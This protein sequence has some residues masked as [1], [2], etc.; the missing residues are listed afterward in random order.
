[1][2]VLHT[3]RWNFFVTLLGLITARSARVKRLG[4]AVVALLATSALAERPRLGVVIVIDQLS[5]E[6]FN[7]RLP[8]VTGGIKRLVDEGYSFHEGRYEAAPT[9]TS[10]GHATIMTGAY[11]EVHGIVANDWINAD[12]GKPNLS[13]E[14]PAYQVLGRPANGREGSA[15]TWLRAPTLADTVRLTN[16]KALALSVSAKDRSSI[17]CAGRGGL[18]VWFDAEKPF[19]TTS[20]FYAKELPAFLKP[21]NDKLAQ[22]ILKGAFQWGLPAGGVD[23]QAPRL[24]P[25]A[26]AGGRQGDSEIFAERPELQPILDTAEVDVAIDGIKA[27]GLGKDEIPDLLTI[28][29]SGHDR[30]GHEFGPDS[31][32]GIAEFLH[33]DQEIGRLLKELDTLVGKGKYVVAFTSDH[34]AAPLPELVKSRGLDAGR[35]DMKKLKDALDAALDEALGRQDWFAGA[36]TPGLT[37]TASLREKAMT[38]LP[39]LQKIARTNDGVIDLLPLRDLKG[40]VGSLFLR[41]AFPGR[42]PDLFVITR[43]FWIYSLHDKTGHASLYLYDRAVPVVFFGAGVKKGRGGTTELINLAPTLS[44]L[45]T[46]PNPAAAQGRSIDE[47]FR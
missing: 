17:L 23:G 9:I 4:L 29:F 35:L 16:E 24:E 36:K 41:G 15:P 37:F 8:K 40:P 26:P 28:S 7:N 1:M 46:I 14:D 5:A 2:A 11:G 10:V 3:T 22:M 6:A 12:T 38:Q 31:P 43:P 13:T 21:T 30:I 33:I 20:T 47:V 44:R 45:L 19:F 34:G 39:L 25:A 42:S 18:A 27:L 32:E